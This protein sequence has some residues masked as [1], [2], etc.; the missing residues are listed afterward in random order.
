VLGDIFVIDAVTHAFNF[1]ESNFNHKAHAQAITDMSCAVVGD[2]PAP[3]YALPRE[4]VAREW[5]TID[6]ANMLF[7]ESQ[8]DVA[9]FHPLPIT[10]FT[11][12][13]CGIDKAAE[14]VQKW[15]NRF[16][17]AYAVLDPLR[18]TDA[19]P[20][21]EDQVELLSPQGLKLYPSSWTTETASVWS[22]DDPKIAFPIFEKALE[23]GIRHVA[24]HKSIPLGP[25]YGGNAFHPGD[26]EGAAAA[27]PDLNFEIVHGGI[28]FTEETAWLVARYPNIYINM[29]N[30]NITLARRPRT[31]AQ[32]ML[33]LMHVGGE[34][35][36]DKLFWGTGTMQYHPRPCLEA[37][38]NFTFPEDLLESAGLFAPIPQITHERKHDLL[39]R[40]YARSHG[41]D[42]DQLKAGIQHDEFSRAADADL[43]VP[44]STTTVAHL[45]GSRG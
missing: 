25:A 43:P 31:F 16:V 2:P 44:Y 30:L 7:A 8:T 28:A 35:V 13:M 40:N 10:A 27:F 22:M 33:G 3:E 34:P 12:G 24:V 9:I 23:L 32:I 41:L 37:L 1:A 26:V 42:I 29:E 6:T 17:G 21:L 19:F 14:A 15:P 11:D 38:L 39:G 36:L 45:A 20:A 18:G 4:A 5:P